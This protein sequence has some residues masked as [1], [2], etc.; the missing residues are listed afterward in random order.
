MYCDRRGNG[1]K[2]TRTKP[3]GQKPLRTIEIE[4]GQGIFVQDFC[5]RPIKKTYFW[6]VPGCVTKCD[7]GRGGQNWPK[8]AWRTLWTAPIRTLMN[9]VQ[10]VCITIS[11]LWNP[12]VVL[13]G[14]TASR[15]SIRVKQGRRRYI[16]TGLEMQ[17]VFL[18][19]C[20]CLCEY[21]VVWIHHPVSV[22]TSKTKAI[23]R[24][25]CYMRN[26]VTLSGQIF[27]MVIDGFNM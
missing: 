27:T 9:N 26:R 22:Y 1:Q 12:L 17:H 15:N 19:M 6:G 11:S 13:L 8:I 25:T 21:R 23:F 10:S 5:T 4:F 20:A 14:F 18:W 24:R 2:P 16:K 7:R 3:L